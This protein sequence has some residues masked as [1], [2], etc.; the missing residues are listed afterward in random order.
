[1]FN[2]LQPKQKVY[3]ELCFVMSERLGLSY[4]GKRLGGT[5]REELCCVRR[6]YCS[7]LGGFRC[8]RS[9]GVICFLSVVSFCRPSNQVAV[10]VCYFSAP[11]CNWVARWLFV[12]DSCAAYGED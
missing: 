3:N 9:H 5:R 7:P 10:P 4:G 2:T 12:C 1:M 11:A 8:C 6:L